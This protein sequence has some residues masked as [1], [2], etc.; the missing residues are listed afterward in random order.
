MQ[1]ELTELGASRTLPGT[2]I[3]QIRSI[4][5]DPIV[6]MQLATY[7]V[8]GARP[9]DLAMSRMDLPT[10]APGDFFM[11]RQAQYALRSAAW[12]WLDTSGLGQNRANRAMVTVK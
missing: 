12:D 7:M 6:A 4:A 10:A 2:L 5:I 1:A 8:D 9:S 11:S 3:S